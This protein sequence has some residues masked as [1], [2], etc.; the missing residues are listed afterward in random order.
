MVVETAGAS[1]RIWSVLVPAPMANAL[2]SAFA[3]TSLSFE[4]GVGP[5][6]GTQILSNVPFSTLRLA[7]TNYGKTLLGTV[8]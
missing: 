5:L 2:M 8:K 6:S 7:G 1:S 3:S 4:S